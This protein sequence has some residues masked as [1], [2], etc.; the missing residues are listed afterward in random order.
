[1]MV[2]FLRLNLSGLQNEEEGFTSFTFPC[3]IERMIREVSFVQVQCLVVS[4][5]AWLAGRGD[6]ASQGL[7]VKVE[8]KITFFALPCQ[9]EVDGSFRLPSPVGTTG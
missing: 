1:M 8:F 4:Q 6:N 5:A 9:D 7:D 2:Q 3:W